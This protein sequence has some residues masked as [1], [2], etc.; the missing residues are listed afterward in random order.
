M[1]KTLFIAAIVTFVAITAWAQTPSSGNPA[2]DR[3]GA[4][5]STGVNDVQTDFATRPKA[6]AAS[7]H[8]L[9][10]TV[11]YSNNAAGLGAGGSSRWR[12][13]YEPR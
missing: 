5:G 8:P 2:V 7:E 13:P 11:P 4:K 9:I 3:S 6:E 1:T 10:A 12:G